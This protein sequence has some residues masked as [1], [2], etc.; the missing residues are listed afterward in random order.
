MLHPFD[1]KQN[2]DWSVKVREELKRE[3]LAMVNFASNEAGTFL[4]LI[5]ANPSIQFEHVEQIL[6]KALEVR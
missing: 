4:R 5:L 2:A 1:S 3:N 6:L